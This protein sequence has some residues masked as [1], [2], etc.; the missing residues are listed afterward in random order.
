MPDANVRRR[1][2]G[3]PEAEPKGR[4]TTHGGLKPQP[5]PS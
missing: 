5:T 3:N 2:V 1:G 4:R